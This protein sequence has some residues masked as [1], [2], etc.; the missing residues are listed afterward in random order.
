VGGLKS[1]PPP[2]KKKKKVLCGTRCS[3]VDSV[4]GFNCE[5]SGFPKIM[6]M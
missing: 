3:A 6:K 2:K 1:A 5:L 4:V